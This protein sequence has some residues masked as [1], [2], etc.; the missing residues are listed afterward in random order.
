MKRQGISRRDF[1]KGAAAGAFGVAAAGVLGACGTENAGATT[2]A[3][4]TAAPTEAGTSAATTEVPTTEA[5]PP[6]VTAPTSWRTAPAPIPE[7]QIKEVYISDV[8]IV[9]AGNA[10]MS[11]G[12]A[13]VQAGASVTIVEKLGAVG[14]GR[15]WVG[16]L[17]S[18]YQ[19]KAG[20]KINKH[21][22]I[23]ELCKYASH[24]AD[25]RLIRLWADESGATVD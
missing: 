13:A 23:E 20:I 1:L 7:D 2:T 18:S 25:Q 24:R 16:A 11:A 6:E 17:G 12:M 3:G 19:E 4:T 21:E 22:V 5:I 8:V 14:S 15:S 9:G 10:G